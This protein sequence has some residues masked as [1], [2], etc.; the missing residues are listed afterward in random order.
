MESYVDSIFVKKSQVYTINDNGT[1]EEED[2]PGGE[3]HSGGNQGGT[4][5][6]IP[7]TI[8]HELSFVSPNPVENR[9]VTEALSTKATKQ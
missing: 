7:I 5:I 1:V 8:D 4:V 6:S 9:A 2:N 3:S